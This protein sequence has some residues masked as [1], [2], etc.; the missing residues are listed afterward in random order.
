MLFD[1]RAMDTEH[2][3]MD[4]HDGQLVMRFLPALSFVDA[5]LF[6]RGPLMDGTVG[7]PT[8]V[9]ERLTHLDVGARP[10]IA[11]WQVHGI[12]ISSSSIDHAL[13]AHP[14]ADGILLTTMDVEGSL[15]YG[16]CAPVLVL[17]SEESARRDG[18]WA[19][20]LHSGYK[21]TVLGVVRA[22]LDEVERVMGREAVTSASAWIGPCIAGDSYPR[23]MED[24]TERGLETFHLDNVRRSGGR[25]YFDIA[26]ELRRQLSDCAIAVARIFVSGIDTARSHAMCYSYR[27]GDEE[28]RMFLHVRLK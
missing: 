7:S 1:E 22:G 21:G 13:P 24:W 18:P 12:T 19:L 25:F 3:V 11:P 6:M 28:D 27:S 2:F 14:K 16:D 15:R 26:G 20:L 8:V 9:C 10:L 23:T 4:R 17:P 5:R